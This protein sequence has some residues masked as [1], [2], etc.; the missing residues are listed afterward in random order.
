M[1]TPK[2]LYVIADG[3]RARFVTRD[4]KGHFKT[5]R[6]FESP[7]IH[8]RAHELGRRAPARVDESASPTRHAVEARSN[9]K[10]KAEHEFIDLVAAQINGGDDLPAYEMLVI[11][12]TPRLLDLF[13]RQLSDSAAARLKASLNKD[14]TKIPDDRLSDHLPTLTAAH[15]QSA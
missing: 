9:L 5:I 2:V 15:A 11:A 10:D 13:K 14:L 6:E 3:G 8:E 4:S 12:A 7:H 1:H